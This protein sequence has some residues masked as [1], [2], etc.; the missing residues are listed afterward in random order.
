MLLC[1]FPLGIIPFLAFFISCQNGDVLE[2][3]SRYS[4][5]RIAIIGDSISTFEG[6]TPS[7]KVGY[8]GIAYK[9]YYPAGDVI[10]VE[11]TWWY[12]VACSLGVGLENIA[13]CSWSGS[14]VTGNSSSTTNAFAGCSSKRV[15]DLSYNGLDPDIVICFIS[16]NDW[17]NNVPLGSWSVT[18]SFPQDGKISTMREAY[19]LMINKVHI[20]YPEAFVV[21]LTNLVDSKRD[22]TPGYPSNNSKGITVEEWNNSIKEISSALGCYTI[23][24]QEAGINYGNIS[25]F[26]VD[27]GLHPN[28]EG[29]TLIANK[30]S[31]VLDKL[32]RDILIDNL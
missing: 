2:V 8:N 23:D 26:S 13:N 14:F 20:F 12:K 24:L 5:L 29:M 17:A 3:E 27:N 11:N 4:E 18:D 15:I 21:C 25:L 19:A 22:R 28:D 10:S 6:Y 1:R 16:C 7:N 32:L 30:V 9:Y 31:L